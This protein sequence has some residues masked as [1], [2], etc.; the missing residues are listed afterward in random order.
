[1]KT[2]SEISTQTLASYK[3]KAGE[4]ITALD[5]MATQKHEEGNEEAGKRLTGQANKRFSGIVKAT[6]K[7][8]D[9]DIKKE[10]TEMTQ[11]EIDEGLLSNIS[12][13][14]KSSYNAFQSTRHLNKAVKAGEKGDKAGEEQGY[15][16]AREHGDKADAATYNR[17]RDFNHTSMSADQQNSRVSDLKKKNLITKESV[18]LA[19]K[20]KEV[21]KKIIKSKTGKG[22][23]FNPEPEIKEVDTMVKA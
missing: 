6:N 18:E 21:I 23:V 10:E 3:K 17:R 7:Q 9:N 2:L 8:F 4:Q 1:M 11:S 19:A 12:N 14:V 13:R 22:D 5:K 16:K 15:A 20:K